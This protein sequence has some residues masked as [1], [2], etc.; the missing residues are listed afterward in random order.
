MPGSRGL[1]TGAATEKPLPP[2]PAL[3]MPLRWC[4]RG[5]LGVLPLLLEP[6]PPASRISG[7]PLREPPA[8]PLPPAAP[9]KAAAPGAPKDSSPPA[10]GCC[11][12]CC[13]CSKAALALRRCKPS[14]WAGEGWGGSRLLRRP[15]GSTCEKWQASPCGLGWVRW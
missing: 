7:V 14:R 15:A 6:V 9:A 8:L 10:P 1:N 11:C 4:S 5:M 13:C 12:C 2:P 3:L